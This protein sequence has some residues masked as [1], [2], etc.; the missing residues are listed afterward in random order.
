M[1]VCACNHCAAVVGK[2]VPLNSMLIYYFYCGVKGY[3]PEL[4]AAHSALGES[5]FNC[6]FHFYS[7]DI[8]FDIPVCYVVVV[9][10]RYFLFYAFSL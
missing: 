4:C 7:V 9:P 2:P 6:P 10:I 3:Y 5:G 8:N 1:E